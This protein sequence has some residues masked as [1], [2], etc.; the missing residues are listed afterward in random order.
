MT[1]THDIKIKPSLPATESDQSSSNGMHR[2]REEYGSRILIYSHDTYGLGHF[3]RCLKIAHET[4]ALAP[5]AS[6]LL[7]TGSPLAQLFVAPEGVDFVKLP[8][9][10]KTGNEEYRPRSL[11]VSIH[12][13]VSLRSRV[14]R[15][16]ALAFHPDVVLVDHAPLGLQNEALPALEALHEQSSRPALV[17]GLRDIIDEPI[18]VI[19]TWTKSNMYHMIDRLF[20]HI[21]IYGQQSVYDTSRAYAF[22]TYLLEKTSYAG[23]IS[24]RVRT[25][26]SRQQTDTSIRPTVLVTV[27]GGEDGGR[28]VDAYIAMIR[29]NLASISFDSVVLAGPLLSED[30]VSEIRRMAE[31]LPVEVHHYVADVPSLLSRSDLVISMGGYNAVSEIMA[32]AER[33]LLV[34][35]EWPRREQLIRAE[36][37]YASGHVDMLRVD[38]LTTETLWSHINDALSTSETPLAALRNSNEVSL[39]GASFMAATLLQMV[40]LQQNRES[41]K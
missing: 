22:P 2:A 37:L 10:I 33:A 26:E 4:R 9:V 36:R 3:R 23:F 19:D 34:P 35:R 16:T 15:E 18:R 41:S 12:E 8:S 20:D 17:L 6:V 14:I 39:T 38:A 25:F 11:N 1:T 24:G 7:I 31:D 21:V 29:A 27:G 30:R 32:F 13:I 5:N 28:I 40:R